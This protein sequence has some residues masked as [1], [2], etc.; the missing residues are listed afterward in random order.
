MLSKD[1]IVLII[2][3]MMIGFP[4]S[5]IAMNAWLDGFAYRV[6][7]SADVYIIAGVAIILLTMVTVSYQSMRTALTRPFKS[8]RSE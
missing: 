4:I 2:I 5:W 7:I 1:F 3:A 6:K 8:L